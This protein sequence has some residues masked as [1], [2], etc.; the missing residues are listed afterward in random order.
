M[1]NKIIQITEENL[2]KAVESGDLK[3]LAPEVFRKKK[4]T[5]ELRIK[6]QEKR[7]LYSS[8]TF[9]VVDALYGD[10]NGSATLWISFPPE[11]IVIPNLVTIEWEE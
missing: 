10:S 2:R 7:R 8:L 3:Q 11:A 6:I 9:P 4:K 1:S 5:I